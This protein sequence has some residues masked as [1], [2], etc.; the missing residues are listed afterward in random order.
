MA[1]QTTQ[2]KKN[3]FFK[4]KK[5]EETL[6]YILKNY[7]HTHLQPHPPTCKKAASYNFFTETN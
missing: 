5:S 6:V 4:N 2:Q 3:I 1:T 7:K